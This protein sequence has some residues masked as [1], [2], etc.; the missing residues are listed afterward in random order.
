MKAQMASRSI[1]KLYPFFNLCARWRS[2]VN[3]RP[4]PLY[5]QEKDLVPIVLEAGWAPGWRRDFSHLCRPALYKG[6]RVS[7]PGEKLAEAWP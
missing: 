5:P 7:F 2:V 1:H 4:T 6:Y 3:A